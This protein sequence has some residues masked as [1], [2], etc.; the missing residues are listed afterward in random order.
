VTA[1]ETSFAVEAGAP[2]RRSRLKDIGADLVRGRRPIFAMFQSVGTQAFILAINVLTGV[3]TARLLG[4]EGRGVYAAVTIWPTL[5]G[6]LAAAGLNS[7]IVF[8]IRKVPGAAGSIATAALLLASVSSLVAMAIGAMLLPVL[9]DQYS[10]A[11]VSFAQACLVCVAVN[12]LQQL[13]RQAFAAVGRFGYCNLTQLLPQLFHLIALVSIVVVTALTAHNAIL[14]L[15]VSGAVAV[16]AL[17][18]AFIRI[19][20]PVFAHTWSELRQLAFFGMRAAPMD[21]VFALATSADRLVLIP[22]LPASDL[23]FYAVAFSFSRVIQLVQPAI[24]S[25][26]LAQMSAQSEAGGRQLHD[27][28]CRFLI[29]ALAVGCAVL[30]IGGERLLAFTYGAQFAS[31]NTVFRIL[32]VE[33]SLAVISQVTVQ[34]FLA[35]DRPGVVS[36]I[37]VIV[38]GLSLAML[39]TLVP[40]YGAVGAAAALLIAGAARWAML[41]AAVKLVLK[42]PLPRLYLLRGDLQYVSRR[43]R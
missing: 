34:L 5:F 1:P 33:A 26:F 10:P 37:Q 35:R 11:I 41:L 7:A 39:L 18:P 27:H 31:A 20:R 40:L 13:L 23:G 6:S 3:I 4:P 15:L 2:F 8:R 17:L 29:A 14:A 30:W 25:V 22:L 36:T 43:L 32:V 24:V 9:M 19:L 12:S 21:L 42:Q 38:L 16:L 28:A